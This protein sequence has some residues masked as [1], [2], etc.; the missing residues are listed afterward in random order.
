MTNSRVFYE[1]YEVATGKA[2]GPV[3]E[4]EDA[5]YEALL[6]KTRRLIEIQ[7]IEFETRE[8]LAA[9]LDSCECAVRF[10][11]AE[12]LPVGTRFEE[13]PEDFWSKTP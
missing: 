6:E 13:K 11:R 5:L 12:R 4:Y 8:A 2:V 10:V 1:P 3:S 7:E 9:A